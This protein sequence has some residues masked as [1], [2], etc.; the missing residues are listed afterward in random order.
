MKNLQPV[1]LSLNTVFNFPSREGSHAP[2]HFLLNGKVGEGA[3]FA[4]LVQKV[5]ALPKSRRRREREEGGGG[6]GGG[7]G[8]GGGGG[9]TC[10]EVIARALLLCS[11]VQQGL[12]GPRSQK[13]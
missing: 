12:P 2:L 9:G 8:E 11:T 10:E 6:G 13:K 7:G 4:L 3:T 1:P 5:T